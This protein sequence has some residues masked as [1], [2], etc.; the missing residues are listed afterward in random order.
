MM[1]YFLA[2]FLV[3]AVFI[4]GGCDKIREVTSP[5]ADD[6]NNAHFQKAK[7]K[8]GRMDYQGAI[9]AYERALRQNPN[10]AKAHLE[11]ALIYED[12]F[13]DHI[14]AIYHFRKYSSLR[15]GS[16]KKELVDEFLENSMRQLMA[17]D[18]GILSNEKA[19]IV[20]LR[21]ENST[22]LAQNAA[23]RKQLESR[24]STARTTE[25]VSAVKTPVTTAPAK[26]APP[27]AAPSAP[28]AQIAPPPAPD[29]TTAS[30][31]SI[32][33]GG[34]SYTV[35]NG[36]TLAS[37]SRKFYNSSGKWQ[38]ILNANPSLGKPEN[39]K[40]GQTIVIPE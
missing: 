14:S 39:L 12:K 13:S 21:A 31:T 11:M 19:E 17:Q 9:D 33:A 1:R 6:E 20:R 8:Y 35:Q 27:V 28:P 2:A 24:A 16:G 38:K 22:L 34:L 36:D 23:L 4:C 3:S 30:T 15:P 10:L 40:P 5:D 32:P 7:E 25:T 37:I 29:K 26:P 18:S